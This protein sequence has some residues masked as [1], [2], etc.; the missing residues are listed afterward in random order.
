V[1]ARPQT[2]RQ[3]PAY[4]TA[5]EISLGSG[6]YLTAGVAGSPHGT[7]RLPASP[8]FAPCAQYGRKH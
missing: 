7:A 1:R 2:G 6:I 3:V 4:L 8:P 5:P